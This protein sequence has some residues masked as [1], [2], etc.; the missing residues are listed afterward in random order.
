MDGGGN[1]SSLKSR[2]CTVIHE[3]R[4]ILDQHKRAFLLSSLKDLYEAIA[5]EFKVKVISLAMSM[6]GREYKSR[7]EFC[8]VNV[9][10]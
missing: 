1:V 7:L 6:C 2:R 9:A 8:Q 3:N 4:R 10:K 5:L